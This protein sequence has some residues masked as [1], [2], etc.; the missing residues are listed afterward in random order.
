[1]IN[2]KSPFLDRTATDKN[3]SPKPKLGLQT[4][5]CICRQIFAFVISFLSNG[6]AIRHINSQTFKKDYLG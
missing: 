5:I 6:E 4:Q 2:V 3:K 1:M